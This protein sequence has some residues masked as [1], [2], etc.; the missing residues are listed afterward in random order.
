MHPGAHSHTIRAPSRHAAV[1]LT[2]VA[3]GVARTSGCSNGFLLAFSL[4]TTCA[5]LINEWEDGALED[6]S[7]SLSRLF[8]DTGYYAHDDL[9][10]RTQ[11]VIPGELRNGQA[12]VAQ[13]VMGGSSLVLPILNR[14]LALGRW[15]R[16]FLWELDRPRPRTVLFH[17]FGT[18]SGTQS[19]VTNSQ[20]ASPA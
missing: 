12:H 10:R 1:D 5:L 8:P 19:L 11:N 6:L 17:C 18:S 7:A 3:A 15:Q 9:S 14:E 4:H 20:N 16:L 2:D 13:M